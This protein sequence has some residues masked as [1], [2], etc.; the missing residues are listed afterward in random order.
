MEN[1]SNNNAFTLEGRPPPPVAAAIAF[2]HLLAMAGGILT[3]PLLIALGMGLS[4]SETSY[5]ICSAL[6]ISGFATFVQINRTGPIGSGLLSLQGT[7]FAFVGPLIFSYQILI[8]DQSSEEALGV[9]FGSTALCSLI[10]LAL[11]FSLK[12]LRNVITPNVS[13][14]TILLLGITLVLTTLQNLGRE[15]DSA[16]GFEGNGFEIVIL[17]GSVFASTILISRSNK[18]WLRVGSITFGLI[19]GFS[20]S[21]FF[22][23]VDLSSL[24]STEIFFIPE[25]G[26]YPIS[27]DLQIIAILLPIFLV[28]TMESIGDITATNALSGL[29]TGGSAYWLRLRGGIAACATNSFVASLF[30]TF[31]NTTFSQNNGV[32]RLTGICSRHVGIYA[33]VFLIILGCV[34][35]VANLFQTIPPSVIYGSTVLMFGLVAVSGYNIIA[36]SLPKKR[37]WILVGFAC[38]LAYLISLFIDSVPGL[39]KNLA[40]V[41]SFPVSTGALIA[42]FFEIVVPRNSSENGSENR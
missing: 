39:P 13:G 23:S 4:T 19:F 25:I 29:K 22:G 35:F 40:S 31:P 26:R 32:I 5:L 34:P 30:S 12:H 10:M 24:E 33:A 21:L 6:V 1:Y 16:G 38:S 11:S 8:S 41:L 17:S 28:S 37:D 3:A 14:T 20:I 2:Q 36:E 9:I 42:M 18:T 27:I 15:F 7:S